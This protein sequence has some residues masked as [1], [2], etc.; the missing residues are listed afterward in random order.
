MSDFPKGYSNPSFRNADHKR[1]GRYRCPYCN[2]VGGAHC[3]TASGVDYRLGEFH[4]AR[5][6][7]ASIDYGRMV[8]EADNAEG[9]P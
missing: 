6:R 9:Q 7:A 5:W 3:R 2:A 1:V 8:A 4:S